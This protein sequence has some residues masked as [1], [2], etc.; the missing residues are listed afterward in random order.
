MDTNKT[1]RAS[2]KISHDVLETIARVAAL[3]VQG[4]ASIAEF[5]DAI[6]GLLSKQPVAISISDGIAEVSI[7]INLEYGASIPEVCANVQTGVKNNIQTM[8]GIMVTKVNV[9]VEG[10]V[11]PEKTKEQTES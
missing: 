3:E 6:S 8:T 7:A 5:P 9:L 2:L 1:G 11:F 4:V 10:I